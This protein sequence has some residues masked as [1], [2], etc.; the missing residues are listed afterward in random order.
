MSNRIHDGKPIPRPV[1][2][3]QG[4]EQYRRA[5]NR[6]SSRTAARLHLPEEDVAVE[7]EDLGRGGARISGDRPSSLS[8]IVDITLG[9][10]DF[11]G[12]VRLRARVTRRVAP[13]GDGRWRAALEFLDLQ[14]D[15]LKGIERLIERAI[16]VPAAPAGIEGLRPGATPREVHQVLEAIPLPHRIALARRANAK[17]REVLRQDFHPAVLDALAR[18]PNLLPEEAALLVQSPYLLP[19]TLEAMALDVRWSREEEV[20]YQLASHPR[21]P[22]L[23]AEKLLAGLSEESLRAAIRRPGLPPALRD[24]I[25]RR[26]HQVH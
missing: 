22:F 24:R 5:H 4:T 26:L 15:Q 12:D 25:L 21:T 1:R 19:A 18:N 23:L 7:V 6:F 3:R 10:R 17:E 8:R 14:P 16:G 11:G 13:G 20:R 2:G 9:A